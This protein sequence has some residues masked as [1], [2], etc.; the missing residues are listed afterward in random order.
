MYQSSLFVQSFE[1]LSRN[2]L[3]ASDENGGPFQKDIKVMGIRYQ[4][5]WGAQMMDVT[6]GT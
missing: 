3:P 1:F 2:T 5:R 4:D 6:V